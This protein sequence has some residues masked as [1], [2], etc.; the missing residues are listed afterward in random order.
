MNLRPLGYEQYDVRL[1]RLGPS[2]VVAL[3]SDDGFRAVSVGPGRLPCLRACR[4]VSFTNPLTNTGAGLRL[5]A[6]RGATL[7]PGSPSSRSL[8]TGPLGWLPNNRLDMNGA[9]GGMREVGELAIRGE[10]PAT[11]GRRYTLDEGVQASVDFARRH[12]T[13]KLI[14]TM[15]NIR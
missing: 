7:R 5:R 1:C 8:R 6:L 3:T 2:P 13:G 4:R 14:V 15:L 10:L 11:I 12:T 9:F